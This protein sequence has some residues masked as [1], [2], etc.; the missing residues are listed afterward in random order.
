MAVY[1]HVGGDDLT[2]LLADY[3]LGAV[4]GYEGVA[5]GVEN[6]NYILT[7][8]RGRFIL[9]LFEKRVAEADLPFFM[10]AME[11]L[12]KGGAPVP[13]PVPDRKGKIFNRVCG[14]PAT[15]FSFLHGR[16]HMTPSA[17]DCRE[18]GV[19]TA[20]LHRAAAGFALRRPNTLSLGGWKLIAEKCAA[21]AGRCAPGLGAIVADEL[22]RLEEIWPLALPDGLV[23]ADLFP[24]NVFFNDG[25]I[26][27]VIDF[28]FACTDF[29]AYD[30]AL[31]LNAWSADD[32][33]WGAERASALVAGYQ[34]V[35]RLTHAEC[36]AMPTLLAGAALRILLTRL[37]DWLH[38]IDGAVVTVKDP[39]PYR[40]LL[41]FHRRGGSA[42]LFGA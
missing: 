14:R 19:M 36:A 17:A 7:T 6:T 35:R 11:H 32:G 13:M 2:R 27:G 1:T 23:H 15:I 33:V 31:T 5:Q 20:R 12:A 22:T 16:Q 25:A 21:D 18:M 4:T 37:H 26:S 9:T 29:Y 34:H 3:D 41:L 24:D 28:Y 39:L 30:L 8:A 42:S 10:A 38:R 40:D